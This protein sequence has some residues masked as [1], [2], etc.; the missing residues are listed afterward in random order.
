MENISS[1]RKI[2]NKVIHYFEHIRKQYLEI[3]DDMLLDNGAIYYMN[4]NDGTDFDWFMNGRLCEFM[5]FY[6]S[7]DRGFIKVFVDNDDTISGYLYLNEGLDKGIELQ[8]AHIGDYD[9]L[10][11][12]S[13]L[14]RYADQENLYDSD[15]SLIN[16]DEE[17][18]PWEFLSSEDDEDEDMEE[19]EMID[20]NMG[21]MPKSDYLNIKA[22]EYGYNSYEEMLA[23]GFSIDV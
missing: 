20:T 15:I 12:A 2:I 16:F 13:L 3:T 5:M 23:D 6:K 7:T 9:A 4:A 19:E 17:L 21:S 14:N 8:K 18:K 1:G 22:Y 11:L 10:Y